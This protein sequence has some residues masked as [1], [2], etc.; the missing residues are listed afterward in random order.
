[1]GSRQALAALAVVALTG[2]GGKSALKPSGCVHVFFNTGGQGTT[3]AAQIRT[4]RDRLD[5]FRHK[6]VSYR[7]ISKR[8]ALARMRRRYPYLVHRMPYN[9][10]P[11]AFEATP[12]SVDYGRELV[13]AL[14]PRPAGV[15]AV[16]Y[17]RRQRR[18]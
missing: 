14:T 6:L 3:T 10:F 18:C 9:P 11:A 12:G 13:D 4:V 1:V 8:Q 2:C 7:F 15:H 5:S 16:R 17:S